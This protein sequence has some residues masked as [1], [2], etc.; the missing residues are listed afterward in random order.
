MKS[1]SVPW[2]EESSSHPVVCEM[3]LTRIIKDIWAQASD[4]CFHSSSNTR[5]GFYYSFSSSSTEV[6]SSGFNL[7]QTSRWFSH[8]RHY[9]VPNEY[10]YY[11]CY[12]VPCNSVTSGQKGEIMFSRVGY[13]NYLL[14][15]GL[16]S[17]MTNVGAK[18]TVFQSRLIGKTCLYLLFLQN[19]KIV[20]IHTYNSLRFP[21]EITTSIS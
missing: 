13:R 6:R 8:I 19:F 12:L 18:L 21:A 2:W 14:Q 3:L 10:L 15:T 1:L 4:H 11:Y 5:V 9:I 17:K 7:R 20:P 16:A